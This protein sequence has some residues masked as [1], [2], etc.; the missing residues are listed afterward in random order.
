MGNRFLGQTLESFVNAAG[1]VVAAPASDRRIV[2]LCWIPYESTGSPSQ[3]GLRTGGASGDI[4][5]WTGIGGNDGKPISAGGDVPIA[6]CDYGE[7]L[8]STGK[9]TVVYGIER[10]DASF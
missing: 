7:N 3:V 6:R 9:G 1:E 4:L 10:Q 8:Y 5:L 2:V